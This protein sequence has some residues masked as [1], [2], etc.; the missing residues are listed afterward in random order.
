M[1]RLFCF[2]IV[3]DAKVVFRSD[4][5]DDE[6]VASRRASEIAVLMVKCAPLRPLS[7]RVLSVE[8]VAGIAPDN[9]AL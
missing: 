2:E 1:T 3:E 6:I 7:Y 9:F 8:V 5:F 4:Y